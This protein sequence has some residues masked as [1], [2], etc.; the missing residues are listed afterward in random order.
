MCC[1]CYTFYFHDF[2]L[3]CTVFLIFLFNSQVSFKRLKIIRR[4]LHI[5]PENYHYLY[6]NFCVYPHFHLVYFSFSLIYFYNIS[7][8][9]MMDSLRLCI[10]E[11]LLISPSF[12]K[13]TF[14]EYRLLSEVFFFQCSKD[15][16]LISSHLHFFQ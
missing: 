9:V 5:Y 2:Y 4:I 3:P 10:F 15:I 13:N 14:S 8:S 12:Y 6:S 16:A 7:C 11:T 1:C